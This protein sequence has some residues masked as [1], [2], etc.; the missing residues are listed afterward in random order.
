MGSLFYFMGA[1]WV[2]SLSFPS[3]DPRSR[4]RAGVKAGWKDS[5]ERLTAPLP[6]RFPV[7]RRQQAY[8]GTSSA[9]A[10]MRGLARPARR[11]G[12]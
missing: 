12:D 7:G 10:A 5:L 2:P 6:C 9:G 3:V 11:C 4:R 1:E 8:A